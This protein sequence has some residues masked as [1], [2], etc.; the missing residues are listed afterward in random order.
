MRMDAGRA[1]GGQQHG[2]ALASIVVRV[3]KVASE[4]W[5]RCICEAAE[6][7]Q[8]PG[9]IG[10]RRY[11]GHISAAPHVAPCGLNHCTRKSTNT[12]TLAGR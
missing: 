5:S 6:S 3:V 11:A 2:E 8:K 7:Y 4:L 12:R 9:E 10:T 1:G